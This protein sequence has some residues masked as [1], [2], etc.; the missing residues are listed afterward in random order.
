MNGNILLVLTTSTS[1]KYHP[2]MKNLLYILFAIIIFSSCSSDDD[3]EDRPTVKTTFQILNKEPI[4]YPNLVS[5]YINSSNSKWVRIA[6]LGHLTS[7]SDIITVENDTLKNIYL[8]FDKSK[9]YRLDTVF[10]LKKGMDNKFYISNM[11]KSIEVD[12]NNESE[13]PK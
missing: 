4:I 10:V 2:T 3:K 9:T 8:F 11:T 12:K 6:K 7:S 5:G 13:Y 1:L